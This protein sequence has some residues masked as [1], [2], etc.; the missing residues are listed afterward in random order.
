M[1]SLYLRIV[2]ASLLAVG[3]SLAAFVVVAQNAVGR[4]IGE[5]FRGT[6]SL[7]LD[8][9]ARAFERGGPEQASALLAE[10]D[11]ALGANHYLLD[12][13]GRDVIS[14]PDRSAMLAALRENGEP[15]MIDG[16]VVYGQKSSDGRYWLLAVDEPSFS[17]WSFA[18]FYLVTLATVLF[19]SW[20]VWVGIVSPLRTLATAADQLGRGD[21]SV[22]VPIRGKSEIGRLGV[23]FND[24]AGRIQTLMTAERR[25]L[26]DISH[27]LRSPLARLTFAAELARTAPDR[28]AAIDRLQRD[29]D[30]LTSLVGELLEIT[31]AEGDPA[32]RQTQDVDLRVLVEDVVEACQL[33]ADARGCTIRIEGSASRPTPGDPELLRRAVEN[34]LRNAVAY[35]PPQTEVAVSIAEEE[36]RTTVSIRDQGPGV[37]DELLNSIFAPFY[38]VDESREA[39]TGGLGLGLSI[40]ARAVQLHNGTVR[41]EN[42]H[43]G[44]RVI[45]SLPAGG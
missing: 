9:A 10:F 7:Q 4:V 15:T 16:R 34:V 32:A 14:G 5:R 44:L 19:I 20:L 11:R 1:R 41:A 25:L 37:P 21:F 42:A 3:L 27:E 35:A 28:D 29:V 8:Q 39:K 13:Q 2:L 33:D 45:L 31:R 36:A 22:R 26:Q 18:P 12:A 17:M 38:R 40:T 23:S 30:R 24:M 6:Y 43:P